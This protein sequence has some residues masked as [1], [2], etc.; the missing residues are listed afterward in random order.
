MHDLGCTSRL[1][2]FVLTDEA[3]AEEEEGFVRVVLRSGP[4]LGSRVPWCLGASQHGPLVHETEQ[5]FAKSLLSAAHDVGAELVTVSR[6]SFRNVDLCTV[7]VTGEMAKFARYRHP[8]V[9]R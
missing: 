6:M 9:A 5:S 7:E 4:L 1:R 3:D 2:F 8:F